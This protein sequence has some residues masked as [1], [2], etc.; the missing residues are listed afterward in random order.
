MPSLGIFKNVMLPVKAPILF[1]SWNFYGNLKGIIGMHREV[2]V[3]YATL[4]L[5]YESDVINQK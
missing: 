4:H 3:A 2:K 1:A 5:T